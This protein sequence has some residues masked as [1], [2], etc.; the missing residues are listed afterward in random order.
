MS[1]ID[2]TPTAF[3]VKD[4]GNGKERRYEASHHPQMVADAQRVFTLF[5]DSYPTLAGQVVP[6]HFVQLFCQAQDS[7]SWSGSY[8]VSFER[9]QFILLTLLESAAKQNRFS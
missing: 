4:P 6:D 1:N 9:Q 5:A 2:F 7:A 8:G 3:T